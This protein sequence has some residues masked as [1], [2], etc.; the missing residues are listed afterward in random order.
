MF[1]VKQLDKYIFLRFIE[2]LFATF[3][4]CTFIF[5]MQFLWKHINELVGKGLEFTVLLE[6]FYY[7][8]LSI[9]PMALP[10]AILLASLMTFGNLG[11]K[12]ELTALKAAGIS[13]FRIM[14]S[15]LIFISF[16]SIGAFFFSNN[17]LP[18]SQKKLW[19]LIFS[20]R[21][22][23]PELDIPEGEFYDGIAG[24][25]IYVR[26]KD[27]SKKLLKDVMIYNFSKGFNNASVTVADSARI[28][29]SADKTYLLLNLYSGESFENL[30]R[31]HSKQSSNSI[32]YR[33]ETFAAKEVIIDFDMNFSRLD[34]GT[35]SNQYMSKN[36]HQ[37]QGT[38]DT[39]QH[40]V[41]SLST[42][43]SQRFV[44][45]HFFDR[46][47]FQAKTPKTIP[48]N[49]ITVNADSLFFQLKQSNMKKA[50]TQA[51]AQAE[52][53]K[54]D[55]KANY[56]YLNAETYLLNRHKIEWHRKFTLAFACLIFFFIG[57]PLGAI[58]RKGGLGMPVV[59]S[60]GMF[61]IYYM[62][63]FS[64]YKLA[65][66]DVWP[67]WAGIWLSSFCLLPIGIFLTYKAAI[68]SPI[69]NTDTWKNPFKKI[70]KLYIK[71]KNKNI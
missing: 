3:F 63:D 30:Q 28:N 2:V 68:D 14:F 41:D 37:L 17:V 31:Q 25:N 29:L 51:I 20:L 65:R 45:K 4:I 27:N 16:I 55:I 6:F 21:M 36:M 38:I 10:L 43:F 5:L 32:P 18:V 53:Y 9:V 1:K 23:S 50:I 24:Y 46:Q 67:A 56:S 70:K 48:E 42:I 52:N 33:R 54:I 12:T 47:Y 64:G 40:T 60:V 57:A 59:I 22:T 71:N 15:L 69:F 35:L 11:E 34:D 7:A 44:E 62:I 39:L 66:E 58:I 49:K 19:T 13:L 61:L 8:V 26:D